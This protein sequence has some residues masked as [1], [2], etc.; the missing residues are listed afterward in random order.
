MAKKAAKAAKAKGKP[1]IARRKSGGLVPVPI[2]K[3]EENWSV[4]KLSDGTVMRVR[5]IMVEIVRQKNKFDDKGNPVY[6]IT[7]GMIHQLK[8]PSKLRKKKK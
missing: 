8:S 6:T 3:S 5:P 1:K 4:Y 2:T 7:S